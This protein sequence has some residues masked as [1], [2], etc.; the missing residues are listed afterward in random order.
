MKNKLKEMKGITLIALVITII[1]LLILAGVSIATLTGENGI[2]TQATN[3]KNKTKEA[4]AD[5]IFKLI[6]NEWKIEKA[7]GTSLDAFLEEKEEEYG[8]TATAD[9][10]GYILEYNGEEIKIDSNGDLTEIE[11]TLEAG[12]YDENDNLVAD[13]DTLV[14][15]YGFDIEKD[16]EMPI[17]TP[18]DLLNNIAELE[19]GEKLIIDDDIT[20]IGNFGLCN[21]NLKEIIMQDSVTSIGTCAFMFCTNL[22]SITISNNI[23]EIPSQ[24]FHGCTN[25]ININIPDGVSE[26]EWFAFGYCTNLTSITIPD[27]LISIEHQVFSRCESLSIIY[28]PSNVESIG[29]EGGTAPFY[30]CS[31]ELKIYCGASEAQSG[32]VTGWNYYSETDTLDVTYGITREQYEALIVE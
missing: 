17:D 7:K 32:W 3:A 19:T 10:D 25:L 16:G 28:I 2:L 18:G 12:L 5:E 23:T 21:S 15:T 1:V 20:K 9:G 11:E 30:G 4:E 22:T 8:I 27:S 26:I 14:N 24:A 31:S 13:W 6:A 29:Y